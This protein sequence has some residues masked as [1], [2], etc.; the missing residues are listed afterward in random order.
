MELRRHGCSWVGNG[1][2][3]LV[4]CGDLDAREDELNNLAEGHIGV[5]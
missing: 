3:V 4:V 5:C 1:F 2:T